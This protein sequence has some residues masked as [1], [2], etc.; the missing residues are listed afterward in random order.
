[1]RAQL[2]AKLARH[3]ELLARLLKQAIAEA[4][5]VDETKVVEAAKEEVKV[6]AS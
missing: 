4:P 1:M 5:Q 2:E 3:P 6:E